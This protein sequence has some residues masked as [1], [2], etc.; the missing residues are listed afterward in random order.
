MLLGDSCL[1][2]VLYRTL[3]MVVDYA[4]ISKL[5]FVFL[6]HSICGGRVLAACSTEPSSALIFVF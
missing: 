4:R 6:V 2:Y 3:K 5:I 1:Y